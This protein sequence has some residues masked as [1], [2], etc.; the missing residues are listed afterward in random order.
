MT[1]RTPP[2]LR[3]NGLGTRSPHGAV[4]IDAGAGNHAINEE[5]CRENMSGHRYRF[6]VV[7]KCT[8]F[9][10]NRE[11]PI[12]ASFPERVGHRFQFTSN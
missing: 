6:E 5:Q 2:W 12:I 11:P 9:C 8:D 7:W 10:V 4:V 3:V 1:K